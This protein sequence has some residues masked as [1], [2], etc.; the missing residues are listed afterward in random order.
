MHIYIYIYIYICDAATGKVG[1][2]G[3]HLRPHCAPTL[4]QGNAKQPLQ[5]MK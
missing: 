5:N 3:G 4:L 1:L 2:M